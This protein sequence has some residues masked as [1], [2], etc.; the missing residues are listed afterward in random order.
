MARMDAREWTAMHAAAHL[1]VPTADSDKYSRGVVGLRTGSDAY[2]GAAVLGVEAAWRAGAGM[3]RYAG[4]A[5]ADVLARR[6]ET[7]LGAGRVQAWVIGSGTDPASRDQSERVALRGLLDGEV[8]VVVDAG[9][10]DLAVGARAP[11][12]VTPHGREFEGLCARLGLETI[13]TDPESRID[14]VGR[15]SAA[16]GRAILLKGARTLVATPRGM[17]LSV[18]S[19]TPWLSSAG[20]GDVLA[21]VVGALVAADADAAAADSDVLAALVATGAWVHGAA[22]RL[23]A[24]QLDVSA[25]AEADEPVPSPGR[26]IT[27]LDVADAVPHVIGALL[28]V[29]SNPPFGRA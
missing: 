13:D 9:A 26:P 8:P 1:M 19:G 18:R 17:V 23:A 7:V 20:T 4:P 22:G 21:G 12:V 25:I 27:A 3:V 15:A 2:P 24:G 5:G 28:D 6:P 11:L 14:A 29:F 16:L 10:I